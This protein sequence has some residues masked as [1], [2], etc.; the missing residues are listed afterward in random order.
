MSEKLIEKYIPKV[1]T[2]IILFDLKRDYTEK[3]AVTTL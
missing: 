1:S 2:V 3:F